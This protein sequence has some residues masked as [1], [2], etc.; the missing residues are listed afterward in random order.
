[1]TTES[2]KPVESEPKTPLPGWLKELP[3]GT[4]GFRPGEL[5]LF[6]AQSRIGRSRINPADVVISIATARDVD[7]AVLSLSIPK[8]RPPNP[9][10]PITL[11]AYGLVDDNGMPKP[12]EP[13]SERETK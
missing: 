2:T 4:G 13:P 12:E 11:S 8:K 6:Q 3:V 10:Y 7:N 9:N 1:M 5:L